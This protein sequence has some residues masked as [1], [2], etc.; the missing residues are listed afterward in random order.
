MYGAEVVWAGGGG[1]LVWGEERCKTERRERGESN[2]VLS[3]AP[4]SKKKSQI[5]NLL[6][7]NPAIPPQ[8]SPPP[9]PTTTTTKEACYLGLSLFLSQN[10]I[11]CTVTG[12]SGLHT[13]GALK[14]A[15]GSRLDQEDA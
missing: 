15:V 9:P 2:S 11:Q 12:Q 4:P 1:G 8:P 5:S 10:L 14:L 3:P 7:P 6:S 13:L